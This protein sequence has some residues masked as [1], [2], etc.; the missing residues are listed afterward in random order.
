MPRK[1]QKQEAGQASRDRLMA[2]Q[3]DLHRGWQ[4]RAA[5]QAPG[6]GRGE[7]MTG[8]DTEDAAGNVAAA[9]ARF[10]GRRPP[11]GR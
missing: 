3:D 10:P 4:R 2:L 8:D 7:E 11:A 5:T 9:R 6:S 1:R